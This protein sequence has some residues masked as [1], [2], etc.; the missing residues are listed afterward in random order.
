L[1]QLLGNQKLRKQNQTL[2]SFLLQGQK[3]KFEKL[4]SHMAKEKRQGKIIKNGMKIN[5]SNSLRIARI[6][7]RLKS[8][9]HALEIRLISY[10][11]SIHPDFK[12][13]FLPA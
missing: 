9:Y 13:N 5:S 6:S 3:Q 7:R 10:C 8:A 12:C 11:F 2:C 4:T 1:K